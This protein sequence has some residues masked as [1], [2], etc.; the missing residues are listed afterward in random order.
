MDIARVDEL[1]N[2]R[3]R[4]YPSQEQ[5]AKLANTLD[6]CRWLYN[7]FL[8]K[9]IQSKEDMQFILTELKEQEPIL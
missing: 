7:H 6:A 3:F 2:Y 4:L 8:N 9:N 1:R 5:E